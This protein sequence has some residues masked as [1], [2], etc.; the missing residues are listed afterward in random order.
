VIFVK[1]IVDTK[2]DSKEQIQ[3]AARFLLSLA[4]GT[5]PEFKPEVAEGAFGMFEPEA[6]L[7]DKPQKRP[8]NINQIVEY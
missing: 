2:E 7:E 8:F 1:I 6:K 4:E 5:S 3:R